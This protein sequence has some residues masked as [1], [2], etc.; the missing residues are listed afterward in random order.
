MVSSRGGMFPGKV[1]HR[2]DLETD[3]RLYVLSESEIHIAVVGMDEKGSE[4]AD[5]EHLL[6]GGFIWMP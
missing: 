2:A 6:L 4:H 3:E 5:E 1:E